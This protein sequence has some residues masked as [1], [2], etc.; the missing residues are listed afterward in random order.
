MGG[1]AFELGDMPLNTFDTWEKLCT[2]VDWESDPSFINGV[3]IVPHGANNELPTPI[4][5]IMDQNNLAPGILERKI[6][7]A[8]YRD[9][10][11]LPCTTS[12]KT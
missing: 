2:N 11:R 8:I 9:H 5:D 6:L 4:R 10:Y 1:S 12:D 7:K 3:R